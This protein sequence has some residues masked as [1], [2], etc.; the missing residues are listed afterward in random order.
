MAGKTSSYSQRLNRASFLPH[1]MKN[2][3]KITFLT[4]ILALAG[5]RLEVKPVLA[6]SRLTVTLREDKRVLRL[7]NYLHGYPLE[8]SAPHFI[9]MADKYGLEKH[10]YLVAAISMLE[11][12]SGLY[13]PTGSYNAWGFGIPTGAQSGIVFK[14]WNEGIEE[15]TKTI[16]EVYLKNIDPDNLTTEELIYRIGPIYAASP[17]WAVRVNSIF[18]K[19]EN[20][21]AAPSSTKTLALDL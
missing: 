2:T 18:E 21:P 20:T 16:K 4:L 8:E 7:K 19:I 5:L 13:I 14:N 15:V 11:S 1:F 17:T 9:A 6:A 3:L 12:T 10:A